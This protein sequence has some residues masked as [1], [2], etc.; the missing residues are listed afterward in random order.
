MYEYV[1]VNDRLIRMLAVSRSGIQT[2]AKNLSASPPILL[3]AGVKLWEF[4]ASDPSAG[5]RWPVMVTIWSMWLSRAVCVV[6]NVFIPAL[7]NDV[8]CARCSASTCI[9]WTAWCSASTS[10]G[11]V[12]CS[13]RVASTRADTVLGPAGSVATIWSSWSSSRFKCAPPWSSSGRRSSVAALMAAMMPM[14]LSSR[15]FR[16]V[17]ARMSR[18]LFSVVWKITVGSAVSSGMRAPAAIAGPVLFSATSCTEDTAKMLL[19]TTRAVTVAGIDLANSGF[20]LMSTVLG[21]PWV[22][23]AT[24][25]TVP[26]RT[27]WYFTSEFCGSPS[28]TLVSSATTETWGSRRPVDLSIRTAAISAATT[29]TPMPANSSW[30]SVGPRPSVS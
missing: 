5:V 28:P 12:C 16:P 26:T 7:I 17:A 6:P 13:P 11:A 21:R 27:P 18:S 4:M 15:G 24:P 14:L 25:R 2:F 8:S 30:R 9:G 10:S 1:G 22:P 20:R 29:I 3:N 23:G 19:G